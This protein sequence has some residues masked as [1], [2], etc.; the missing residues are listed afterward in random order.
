MEHRGIGVSREQILTEFEAL[1]EAIGE[2][3]HLRGGTNHLSGLD[4]SSNYS[5]TITQLCSQFHES[6]D[7]L[8]EAR[9]SDLSDIEVEN[10]AKALSHDSLASTSYPGLNALGE[11]LKQSV[12]SA[13]AKR[14]GAPW[15]VTLLKYLK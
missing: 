3:L 4:P 13:T 15:G 2:L 5:N 7:Q 6:L 10:L 8:T 14:V 12:G 1:V 11:Y 9:I